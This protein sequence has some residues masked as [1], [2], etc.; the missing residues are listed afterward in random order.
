ML[1]VTVPAEEIETKLAEHMH[2]LITSLFERFGVTGLSVELPPR[3][4]TR[5]MKRSSVRLP[6]RRSICDLMLRARG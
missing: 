6:A 1:E 2:P 5:M 3:M 4:A